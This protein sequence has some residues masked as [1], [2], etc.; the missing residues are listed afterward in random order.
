[1]P[2]QLPRTYL[3]IFRTLLGAFVFRRS[4]KTRLTCF[5]SIIYCHRYLRPYDEGGH[6]MKG[7]TWKKDE[8]IPKLWMEKLWLSGGK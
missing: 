5:P 2:N 8:S 7:A 4:S 1:M 6:G 3:K